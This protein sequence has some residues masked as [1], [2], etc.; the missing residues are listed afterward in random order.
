MTLSLTARS[1]SLTSS[2]LTGERLASIYSAL[3]RV[4]QKALSSHLEDFGIGSEVSSLRRHYAE[5]RP[6]GF[7][8]SHARLAAWL[9]ACL[10]PTLRDTSNFELALSARHDPI[11]APRWVL[12]RAIQLS[13]HQR[14]PARPIAWPSAWGRND[15]AGSLRLAYEGLLEHLDTLSLSDQ[16][17]ELSTSAIQWRLVAL[18]D[19]LEPERSD[20]HH[21]QSAATRLASLLRRTEGLSNSSVERGWLK[22]V[23]ASLVWRRHALTHLYCEPGGGGPPFTFKT[24]VEP[25]VPIDDL[26]VMCA[27]LSLAVMDSVA[28]ALRNEPEGYIRALVARSERD[29][30]DG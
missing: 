6:E 9:V 4:G 27:G 20:Q 5:N 25:A 17:P 21:G 2:D 15:T 23:D 18:V 8:D 22:A 12:A 19:G 29:V 13:Q 7:S 11:V 16:G 3:E 30:L 28:D 14:C 10:G 24:C 26:R 1:K